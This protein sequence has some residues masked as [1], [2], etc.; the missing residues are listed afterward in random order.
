[1][2]PRPKGLNHGGSFYL[3]ENFRGLDQ[4][5]TLSKERYNMEERR[6]H[7]NSTYSVLC[8]ALY[9]NNGKLLQPALLIVQ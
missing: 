9:T 8:Q 7:Y 2:S 5:L 4:K 6:N 3:G 1:M